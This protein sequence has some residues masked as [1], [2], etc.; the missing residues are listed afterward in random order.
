M[1]KFKTYL[2]ESTQP[3]PD[4]AAIVRILQA[5]GFTWDSVTPAL[6]APPHALYCEYPVTCPPYKISG[7][8]KLEVK[9]ISTDHYVNQVTGHGDEHTFANE[10]NG[11][12]IVF[13][14][15]WS[16]KGWWSQS[17]G[18][19]YR[20]HFQQ[21]C[22]RVFGARYI[23]TGVT[24]VSV[25]LQPALEPIDINAFYEPYKLKRAPVPVVDKGTYIDPFEQ[26][27][28]RE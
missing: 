23:K 9:T 3:H 15:V 7:T 17:E 26:E 27:G 25:I 2:A 10:L 12:Y 4:L 14:L 19:G 6:N 11:D 13:N 8:S 28:S 18:I 20:Q 24:H 1:S 16:P 21:E 5:I 22:Q